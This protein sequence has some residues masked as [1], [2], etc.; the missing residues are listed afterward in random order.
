MNITIHQIKNRYEICKTCPGTREAGHGCAHYA[1]CCFGRW[2]TN[3]ANDCP[4][5]KW[6]KIEQTEQNE[7]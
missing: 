6:P 3:P 2:R 5:G 7:E 4:L 1:A